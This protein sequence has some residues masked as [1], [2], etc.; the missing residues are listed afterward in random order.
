MLKENKNLINLNP[1]QANAFIHSHNKI[2][3]QNI[4]SANKAMNNTVAKGPQMQPNIKPI[5]LAINNNA[6]NFGGFTGSNNTL[7]GNSNNMK[8]N[9][10][11]G[12]GTSKKKVI[13][14]ESSSKKN[15]MHTPWMP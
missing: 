4:W 10:D 14:P 9:K 1:K 15:P 11:Q 6:I 2:I 5:G 12:G 13:M 3:N 7:Q 8:F